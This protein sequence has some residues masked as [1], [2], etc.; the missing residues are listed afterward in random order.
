MS[1]DALLD[2]AEVA[3]LT[4]AK[5]KNSQIRVLRAN[6]ITFYLSAAGWPRVP[7]AA[8]EGRSTEPKAGW[9]S[10]KG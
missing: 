9:K 2:P 5:R 6:G 10:N 8:L 1:H 7:R 3:F 4:D